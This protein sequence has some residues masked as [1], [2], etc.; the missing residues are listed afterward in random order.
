MNDRKQGCGWNGGGWWYDDDDLLMT[1]LWLF[2][3]RKKYA[4][5]KWGWEEFR[6]ANKYREWE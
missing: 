4:G 2:L 3:V 5:N 6:S 1:I